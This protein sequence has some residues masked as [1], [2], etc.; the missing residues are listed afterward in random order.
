MLNQIQVL[1]R[2]IRAEKARSDVLVEEGRQL[3]GWHRPGRKH[4]SNGQ[5]SLLFP[6][7]VIQA[8]DRLLLLWCWLG[9]AQT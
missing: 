6:P 2:F 7:A 4:Q 1:Y 3:T 8:G 5:E 9:N